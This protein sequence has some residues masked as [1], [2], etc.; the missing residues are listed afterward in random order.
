MSE[1]SV[2]PVCKVRLRFSKTDDMR[3]LSHH[4]L[5]RLLERL[6]RRANLPLRAT[7]GFNPKAKITFAS[8]L[9]LGIIGHEEVVEIELDGDHT[10]DAII[11]QLSPL[12]PEG[13]RFL[14]GN[15][16]PVKKAA[17]PVRAVYFFALPA[18]FRPEL[19]DLLASLLK[20]DRLVIDRIRNVMQSPADAEPAGEERLDALTQAPPV[21]ERKEIKKLDI[22]PFI[23][24]LWRDAT[25]YWMDVA[26]TNHGAI[27]PEELVRLIDLEDYMLDGHSVL[28]RMKLVVEDELPALPGSERLKQKTAQ[29]STVTTV[30][31]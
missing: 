23:H 7:E 22:R 12:V 18:D 13:F 14:R 30:P 31:A 8:A 15:T 29:D 5:M 11:S 4:D 28:E 2:N 1:V 19:S 21:I 3:F 26:I 25:G 20:Q 6:C 16:V 9:G 10:A 27:R 24:N 17:Q